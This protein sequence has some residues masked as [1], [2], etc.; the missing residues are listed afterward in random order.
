MGTHI[1]VLLVTA[2]VGSLFGDVSIYTC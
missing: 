1:D 2:N